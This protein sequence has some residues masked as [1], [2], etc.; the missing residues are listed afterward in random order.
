MVFGKGAMGGENEKTLSVN[1]GDKTER[2]EPL[3]K[4]KEDQHGR[5]KC[6]FKEGKYQEMKTDPCRER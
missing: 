6:H 4:G 5:I 3:E 1:E 2:H